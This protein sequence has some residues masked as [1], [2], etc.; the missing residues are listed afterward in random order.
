MKRYE[1]PTILIES[2]DPTIDVLT[3]SGEVGIGW[4][5]GWLT[6]DDFND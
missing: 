2:M 5:Q 1:T 4:D 3:A 6:D